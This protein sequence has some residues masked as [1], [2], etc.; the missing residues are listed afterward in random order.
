MLSDIR[1]AV[2]TLFRRKT[3]SRNRPTGRTSS[4]RV[5]G[6]TVRNLPIEH[7]TTLSAQFAEV[8][9]DAPRFAQSQGT[10]QRRNRRPLQVRTRGRFERP[11]LAADRHKTRQKLQNTAQWPD[12]TRNR[13]VKPLPQLARV[14]EFFRP[15]GDRRYRRQPTHVSNSPAGSDFLGRTINERDPPARQDT[16]DRNSRR[17]TA[18]AD[19]D[20]RSRV[21]LS[22]STDSRQA[23][24]DVQH[25][26]CVR[27]ADGGQV[28]A[29]VFVQKRIY[30]CL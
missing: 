11:A 4:T 14:S 8:I 6:R 25:P 2:P 29:R 23:V 5:S 16:G 26:R 18:G 12:R 30:V 9:L 22:H 1:A 19:V 28:Q 10:Q 20:Q 7:H 21:A 24:A 15:A 27:R 13:H 3:R 17:S